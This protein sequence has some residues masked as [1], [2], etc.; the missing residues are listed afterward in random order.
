MLCAFDCVCVFL[1]MYIL[2]RIMYQCILIT[3]PYFHRC[4]ICWFIPCFF[5]SL[6]FS[7]HYL[8][9]VPHPFTTRQAKSIGS[10]LAK[11]RRLDQGFIA[12]CFC[13]QD[14][15]ATHLLCVFSLQKTRHVHDLYKLFHV[16][17]DW[18]ELFPMCFPF[19]FNTY[20]HTLRYYWYQPR[21]LPSCNA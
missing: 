5:F 2:C 12:I 15:G 6:V 11:W 9:G 20:R 18:D 4:N 3:Y 8:P 17:R 19:D 14:G 10:L 16:H 13:S 7:W 21:C 1:D